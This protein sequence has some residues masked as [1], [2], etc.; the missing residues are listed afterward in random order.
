MPISPVRRS[1]SLL[2]GAGLALGA[3]DVL[4]TN[5][6]FRFEGRIDY[7]SLNIPTWFN[8][9][10]WTESPHYHPNNGTTFVKPDG[11]TLVQDMRK[12]F[13]AMQV[14]TN[15]TSTNVGGGGTPLP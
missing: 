6:N 7:G 10:P 13:K 12:L 9:D 3:A 5:S 2:L 1:L 4:P 15:N 11:R 14:V 8:P